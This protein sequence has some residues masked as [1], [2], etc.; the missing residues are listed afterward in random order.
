MLKNSVF[1]LRIAYIYSVQDKGIKYDLTKCYKHCSCK[2]VV[3]MEKFQ[4]QRKQRV[5]SLK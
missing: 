1:S 3:T 4:G 2:L 5:D